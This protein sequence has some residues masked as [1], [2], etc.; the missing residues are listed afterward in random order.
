M[1][2]FEIWRYFRRFFA[3]VLLITLAGTAGVYAYC[4]KKQ[5]Y[6]AT[7]RIKYLHDGIQSGLAPDGTPM[8]VNEIYSPTV[9]SRAMD[10][11]GDTGVLSR[12]RCS[13]QEVVSQ[14]Q[15]LLTESQIKKGEE[16]TYFPDEYEVR[17]IVDGSQG[18]DFA[19]KALEAIISSYCSLYTQKHVE[20]PLSLNPSSGLLEKGYDYYECVDVLAQDTADVLNYLADKKENYPGFRSAAT[21]Y[22]YSDLYD[23]YKMLNDYAIPSLY[24]QVMDGPLLRNADSLCKSLSDQIALSEQQ[25]SVYTTRQDYLLKLINTYSEKNK[26]IIEYHYH[27]DST[28]GNDYILKQVESYG[29]GENREI[30][31]D[32][33]ILESVQIDQALQIGRIDRTYKQRLLTAFQSAASQPGGQACQEMESAIQLYETSLSD[34]YALV[35][36]TSLEHNQ[37]LSSNYI[38]TTSSVRVKPSIQ[39]A[40]YCIIGFLFFL[41]AGCGVAVALGRTHDFVEYFTYV[42]KKTGLP[43]RDRIDQLVEELSA[44]LLPDQ[45]ACLMVRMVNLS[46]LTKRYGHNTGDHILQDFAGILHSLEKEG[47]FMGYNGAGQF[48]ALFESCNDQKTQA[49]LQLLAQRVDEYNRLNPDYAIAYKASCAIST[50]EQQYKIRDLLQ[51]AARKMDQSPVQGAGL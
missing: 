32:S 21:G 37:A 47:G 50:I 48:V 1:R 29:D 26:E 43:N 11:V 34:F 39:M 20:L 16:S 6:V 30:T 42:D 25:E 17:L 28:N 10:D 4:L 19:R 22:S 23:I 14:E 41:L 27:T 24:A 45:Y 46:G 12:S 33:L 15:Q 7:A 36:Q 3:L 13:V 38:E 35:R 51:S 49:I 18:S 44:R 31:Y 9:I 5:T 8:D 40:L 2:K